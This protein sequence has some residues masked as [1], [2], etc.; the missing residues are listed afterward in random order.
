MAGAQVPASHYTLRGGRRCAAM[1]CRL[2]TTTLAVVAVA[3]G[4]TPP[5]GFLT[6]EGESTVP[7]AIDPMVSGR[8][9]RKLLGAAGV[10]SNYGWEKWG[11]KLKG[12][13]AGFHVNARLP[14][15]FVPGWRPLK[16]L[17]F[18]GE[19]YR[20][21]QLLLVP[22]GPNPR[23]EVLHVTVYE[24]DSVRTAHEGVIDFLASLSAP[25]V[26]D[27]RS[28]GMHFGDVAFGCY[29]DAP[30]ATL[31]ARN[32]LMV[33]ISS[34]RSIID[35]AERID[36]RLTAKPRRTPSKV[37]DRPKIAKFQPSRRMVQTGSRIPLNISVP[38]QKGKSLEYRLCCTGGQISRENGAYYFE[39]QTPGKHN[40]E[41]YVIDEAGLVTGAER[42]VEVTQ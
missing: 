26:P 10:K 25:R 17:D 33:S 12:R 27:G 19:G 7:M 6:A 14:S 41:L 8:E 35:L 28:Q 32:N 36:A 15:D 21:Q 4:A 40:V 13:E 23:Q 37:A 20:G 2:I 34:Q 5:L 3:V 29:G 22:E 24:F 42:T 11:G 9:G 38:E 1:N 30:C 39:A 16:D 31:F 18:T